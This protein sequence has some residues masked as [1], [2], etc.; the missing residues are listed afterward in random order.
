MTKKEIK[1]DLTGL[2]KE[3]KGPVKN[4][5]APMPLFND[6]HGAFQGRAFQV[7]SSEQN[8]SVAKSN[9]NF[10]NLAAAYSTNTEWE[11]IEK[12]FSLIK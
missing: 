7:W 6:P 8:G 12:T 2:L 3:R 10:L 1:S 9:I 5:G 11:Q 4:P